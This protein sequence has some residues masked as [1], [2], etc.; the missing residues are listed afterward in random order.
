MRPERSRQSDPASQPRW[1]PLA[2]HPQALLATLLTDP[3]WD[4]DTHLLSARMVTLPHPSGT[5]VWG[6]TRAPTCPLGP[7]TGTAASV[8]T[9]TSSSGRSVGGARWRAVRLIKDLLVEPLL[10]LSGT[11]SGQVSHLADTPSLPTATPA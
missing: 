2:I 1:V 11:P 6:C 8:E 3:T 5:P 7:V 10:P 9:V 4:M